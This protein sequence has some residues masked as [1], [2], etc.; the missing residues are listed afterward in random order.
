M[1]FVIAQL[2]F[3]PFTCFCSH[4]LFFYRLIKLFFVCRPVKLL[5][6]ILN[7][8]R[9][10]L[11]AVVVFLFTHALREGMEVFHHLLYKFSWCHIFNFQL[12]YSV[13]HKQ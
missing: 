6:L 7:L 2:C 13:G 1:H 12:D 10:L 5:A 4:Y 9:E 11:K 3:K 8:K